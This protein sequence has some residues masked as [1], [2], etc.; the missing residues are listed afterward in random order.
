MPFGLLEAAIEA[1]LAGGAL[2]ALAVS[3]LAARRPAALLMLTS[4]L[5]AAALG[6]TVLSARAGSAVASAS[7]VRPT[8]SC[9]HHQHAPPPRTVSAS[10]KEQYCYE[11]D[12]IVDES[13]ALAHMGGGV[14]AY[15][16]VMVWFK[17]FTV[18]CSEQA[19]LERM[20]G[21]RPL[22]RATG[23]RALFG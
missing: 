22:A 12:A 18:C 14:T 8:A 1:G 17:C 10:G 5:R 3:Q 19:R 23:C 7:M 6:G 13:R 21:D 11:P 4:V 15:R 2:A 16:D 20:P 9:H